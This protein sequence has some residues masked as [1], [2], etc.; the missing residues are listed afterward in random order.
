M[1]R[2]GATLLIQAETQYGQI[3]VRTSSD[4]VFY[5]HSHLEHTELSSSIG[6]RFNVIGK[7]EKG[8]YTDPW[9]RHADGSKGNY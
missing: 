9:L 3:A 7:W 6:T 8:D 5:F 4:F 2:H 1:V